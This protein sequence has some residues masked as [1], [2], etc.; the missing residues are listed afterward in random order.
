MADVDKVLLGINYHL[1][2]E[3]LSSCKECP[4]FSEDDGCV[5]GL[6]KDAKALLAQMKL[7]NHEYDP[8]DITVTERSQPDERKTGGE[9]GGEKD[10]RIRA[11]R[12]FSRK[13]HK[14]V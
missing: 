8:E 6:L 5:R 1:D 11:P 3:F 10:R 4:Y 9:S 14:T 7:E 13:R 2:E 12:F